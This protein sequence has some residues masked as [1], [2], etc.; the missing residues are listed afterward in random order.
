MATTIILIVVAIIIF[1]ISLSMVQTKVCHSFAWA[2]ISSLVLVSSFAVPLWVGQGRIDT[3]K[4]I[5]EYQVC[6]IE[7]LQTSGIDSIKIL[8]DGDYPIIRVVKPLAPKSIW[9]FYSFSE[10]TTLYVPLECK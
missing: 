1:I 2:I 4:L 10:I 7:V 5:N 9:Y 8:E 3:Y 6:G